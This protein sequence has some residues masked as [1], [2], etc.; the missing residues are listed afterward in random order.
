MMLAYIECIFANTH[1]NTLNHPHLVVLYEFMQGW[2]GARHIPQSELAILDK[3]LQQHQVLQQHNT[4]RHTGSKGL[5]GT[6]ESVV[7]LNS[8]KR[9][10]GMVD[11]KTAFHAGNAAN[12]IPKP[13]VAW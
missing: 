9:W 6:P 5:D 12:S 11:T 1:P 10:Q 8:A 3:L 4:H 2:Q 7:G 13:A